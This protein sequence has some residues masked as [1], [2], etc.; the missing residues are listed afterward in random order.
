MRSINQNHGIG[1]CTPKRNDPDSLPVETNR[2][3]VRDFMGVKIRQ[4]IKGKGKPWWVFVSHNNKRTSKLVG[5]KSAAEEVAS[6]I[7][8]L[9][10]LGK[11]NFGKRKPPTNFKDH[12]DS[13]IDIT[14]RTLPLRKIKKELPL[15]A[16]PLNFLVAGAG[17]EPTTFG[18]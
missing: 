8:A 11:F 2:V 14:I 18:L 6:E 9:L 7:R 5:D 16:N 15:M 17:F 4:K 1:L 10:K 13:W 12:A 3:K